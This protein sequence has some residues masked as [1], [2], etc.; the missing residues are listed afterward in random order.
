M[1]QEWDAFVAGS[2][3]ACYLQTT[4]W[5][6]VKAANGW[7]AERCETSRSGGRVG[8]QVLLRRP[9]LVPWSFAYAPRGPL[10]EG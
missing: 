5:A 10:A 9:R 1:S 2:P 7:T 8:A 6:T 3:Q 4:A